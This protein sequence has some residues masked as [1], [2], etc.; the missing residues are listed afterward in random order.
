MIREKI[1][2]AIDLSERSQREV[3][4]SIGVTAPNLNG[5]L[6]GTRPL[7]FIKLIML[8]EEMA[9]TI[10]PKNSAQSIIPPTELREIFRMSIDDSGMKIKDAAEKAK[11]DIASLSTF[12]NGSRTMPL[13]NIERVMEVF[14][15]DVVQLLGRARSPKTA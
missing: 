9:L 10:G 4:T 8:L 13:R 12:L 11:I 2:E 14:D 1:K 15:L 5:F 6:N 7:P 3:A